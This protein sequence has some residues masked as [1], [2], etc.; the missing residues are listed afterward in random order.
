MKQKGEGHF[1]HCGCNG[2]IGLKMMNQYSTICRWLSS[3]LDWAGWFSEMLTTP[4][5]T[6]SVLMTGASSTYSSLSA[7]S[8]IGWQPLAALINALTRWMNGDSP[9]SCISN[10]VLLFTRFFHVADYIYRESIISWLWSLTHAYIMC[11][12]DPLMLWSCCKAYILNVFSQ[13]DCLFFSNFAAVYYNP[14]VCNILLTLK[15]L[16]FSLL[17][18]HSESPL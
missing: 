9:A 17:E 8:V 12:K 3:K 7:G 2:L 15:S 18:V 13:F 1:S 5:N 10:L 6:H 11:N 4:A 14:S 16:D